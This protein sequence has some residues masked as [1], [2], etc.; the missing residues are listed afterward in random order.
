MRSQDG[1]R[2]H[3]TATPR[4]RALLVGAEVASARSSWTAKDSLAELTMLAETAGLEVVGSLFQRLD[5]PYPKFFIGP[6]KVK[7]VAALCEEH[8]AG[9]VVFD[10]ELSPGQTRN[11]EQELQIGVLDRTA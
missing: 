3:T 11:L 1:K 2:L 8:A 7:E 9:L 4:T 10:D 5:Q 6:G